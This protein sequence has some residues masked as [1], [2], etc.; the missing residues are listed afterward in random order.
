MALAAADEIMIKV[1]TPSNSLALWHSSSGRSRRR[2]RNA[3]TSRSL[4]TASPIAM[5]GM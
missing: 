2:H 1:S 4:N 5:P 3:E